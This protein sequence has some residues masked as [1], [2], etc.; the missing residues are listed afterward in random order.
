MDAADAQTDI[1]R[2][3]AWCFWNIHSRV[4]L[5]TVHYVIFC[6]QE[7]PLPDVMTSANGETERMRPFLNLHSQS[8]RTLSSVLIVIVFQTLPSDGA[9]PLRPLTSLDN[10][11][12]LVLT[13]SVIDPDDAGHRPQLYIDT[14][15]IKI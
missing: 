14:L 9:Q 8:C 6:S 12:I 4:S 10:A 11:I 2:S 1:N 5:L 7:I 13:E 15:P 3:I